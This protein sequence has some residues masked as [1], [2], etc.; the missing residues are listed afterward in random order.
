M[1]G[2]TAEKLMDCKLAQTKTAA[3]ILNQ[4]YTFI[5]ILKHLMGKGH[6]A[7]NDQK[8]NNK[9]RHLDQ[10]SFAGFPDFHYI[11]VQHYI[12]LY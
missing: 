5:M 12:K 4:E 6:N 8:L 2:Q 10:Q 7:L 9:K 1:F 11:F 3:F